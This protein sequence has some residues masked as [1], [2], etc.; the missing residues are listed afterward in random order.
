MIEIGIFD[1]LDMWQRVVESI[2][3][4]TQKR[5]T[6]RAAQQQDVCLHE[7]E[8]FKA[9]VHFFDHD[10]LGKLGHSFDKITPLVHVFFFVKRRGP[11]YPYPKAR[12][13]R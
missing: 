10:M 11:P 9:A 2:E 1:P 6:F 5:R 12:E 8:G 4:V 13:M 7:S 3:D